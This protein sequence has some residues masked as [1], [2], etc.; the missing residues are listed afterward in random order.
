MNGTD[1]IRYLTPEN[2]GTEFSADLGQWRECLSAGPTAFVIAPSRLD[3]VAGRLTFQFPGG[4]LRQY[5]NE[6]TGEPLVYIYFA[7]IRE[8]A[9]AVAHDQDSDS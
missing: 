8:W 9:G 2:A 1:L 7:D 6:R 3:E 4:E 5:Q